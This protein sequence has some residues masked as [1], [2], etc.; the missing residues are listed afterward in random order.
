MAQIG[1]MA[2]VTAEYMSG[3]TLRGKKTGQ[4]R[5]VE[6]LAFSQSEAGIIAAFMTKPGWH[7]TAVTFNDVRDCWFAH[8]SRMAFDAGIDPTEVVHF[9]GGKPMS[10]PHTMGVYRDDNF[11]EI[12]GDWNGSKWVNLRKSVA[13]PLPSALK[14]WPSPSTPADLEHA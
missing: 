1:P 7:P 5:K 13:S 12:E 4:V 2:T 6:F 8:A 10:Y 9:C 11:V 3:R 14:L